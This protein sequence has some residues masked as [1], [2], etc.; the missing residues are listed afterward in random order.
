MAID[1]HDLSLI[2]LDKGRAHGRVMPPEDGAHFEQD[3]I[4]FGVDGRLAAKFI[5]DNLR[6]K[7]SRMR[8]RRIADAEASK[9]RA[10]AL[11][12]LG[13]DP[14]D[15]D[16]GALSNDEVEQ[17]AADAGKTDDADATVDLIIWARGE[18]VYRWP[19]LRKA[20]REQY[21]RDVESKEDLLDF[22]VDNGFI[23][24]DEAKANTK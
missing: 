10:A 13:V 8:I 14:N 3:G 12:R 21:S 9:A 6:A 11:A 2:T 1:D 17:K 20:A 15:P 4:Y 5:D 22:M 23:S 16:I 19:T 7:L 18:K 24:S